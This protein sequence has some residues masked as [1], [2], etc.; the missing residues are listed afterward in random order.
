[1]RCMTQKSPWG[2]VTVSAILAICWP[3]LAQPEEPDEASG[4][5]QAQAL[6]DEAFEHI[7][8]GDHEE[9][10]VRF[11]GAYELYPSEKLLLNIGTVLLE[12]DERAAAAQA[13]R[14]YLDHPG[15]SGPRRDR[16][17]AELARLETRVARIQIEV[18]PDAE[19][20][21]DGTAVQSGHEASWLVDAEPGER[22]VSATKSGFRPATATVQAQAGAEHAVRLILKP[23]PGRE[24]TSPQVSPAS[25]R[26]LNPQRD[27]AALDQDARPWILVGS[28][29][30]VLAAGTGLLVWALADRSAVENADT[31]TPLSEIERR[32]KRVPP[33]RSPAWPE[34]RSAPR[35]WRADSPGRSCAAGARRHRSKL[36]RAT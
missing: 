22:T 23:M 10:L 20:Q 34:S 3:A 21:V 29:G 25:L 13:Y 31:G 17:A 14:T 28:G 32:Q 4:K 7:D 19:V 16:V 5:I 8:A 18:E 33:C 2:A 35:R 30:V 9:A 15:A 24:A 27:A 36:G 1:M 11:R 26:S 12:L 6:V